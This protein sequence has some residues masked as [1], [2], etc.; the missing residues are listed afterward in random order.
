ML[1]LQKRS[2][3]KAYGFPSLYSPL[4]FSKALQLLIPHRL[5]LRSMLSADPFSLK[6]NES[7]LYGTSSVPVQH[8]DP[9]PDLVCHSSCIIH[10]E[11]KIARIGPAVKS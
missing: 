3:L 11:Q 2:A 1:Q 4:L 7:D 5:D 9:P 8:L 10:N 6:Q